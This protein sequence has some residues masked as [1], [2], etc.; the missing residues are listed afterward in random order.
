MGSRGGN[1][2]QK[3]EVDMA[4]EF[5]PVPKPVKKE[6]KKTGLA[7]MK[8]YNKKTPKP[9]K[10]KAPKKK[11]VIKAEREGVKIPNAGKRNSFSDWNYQKAINEFG[12]TCN[13]PTCGMPASEMHH[14]VFRSGSGRGV[15][16]NA[17]PL[18]VAH[19]DLCHRSGR[20]ANMWRD[21]R[22]QV[23]GEHFYKDEWDLWKLG[24]IVEPEAH[25]FE[26]FMKSEEVRMGREKEIFSREAG[27]HIASLKQF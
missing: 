16:R 6:K 4:H 7:K 2:K 21:T 3:G 26:D 23:Y 24:L 20:Y 5:R 10:K 22:R 12:R 14:I 15:W 27:R 9:K 11:A 18:C 13:D 1:S 25:F 8:P 17:V 19:H